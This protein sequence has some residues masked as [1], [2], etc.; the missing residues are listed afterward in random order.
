MSFRIAR[1][2]FMSVAL[3]A[4]ATVVAAPAALPATAEPDTMTAHHESTFRTVAAPVTKIHDVQGTTNT[5]PRAGQTVTVEGVVTSLFTTAD[6]LSGFFLQEEDADADTSSSTSEGVFVTCGTSCTTPV[7]VGQVARV[8]GEVSEAFNR[9]RISTN[10]A[11]G[12]VAVQSDL[13]PLP[14]PAT[15]TLPAA[16]STRAVDTFEALEGM[17]ITIATEMRVTEFFEEARFGHIVLTSGARPYT[18]THVDPTPTPEEHQ[19]FVADLNTRR[20]YLDDDN[21]D[22]NDA[23][24]GPISNEAYP[25]PTSSYTSNPTT[26]G[27]SITNRMRA[28]DT[29]SSLTGVMDWDFAGSASGSVNAW[30]IRP[31]Q[32]APYTFASTNPAPAAPEP[33]G[34]RLR[35]SAFNVL[36]YFT[37]ID[38]TASNST[39][40]CGPTGTADCRGADSEAELDR[41]RDK[42]IA[43]M[44]AMDADVAGLMEIQNDTG[45][46]TED[47]VT[48]LDA[49]TAPGTYE[50]IDT[51]SIGG[52]AIKVAIIYQPAMVTPVGAFR[53]LTSE[54]DPDFDDSRSRPALI[55]T[56]REVSTGATFTV[57]VNHLK[58]KGSACGADDPDTGDG[59][60]NCNLTR[61]KA[62]QALARYLATDPT[63]SGDPDVLILGDLNAYRYED[64]ITALKAAGYTDLIQQFLG[65]DA[66]SYLFDGQVG[67]LDHALATSS[68]TSQVTGVAEWHVNADEPPLFDYNDTVDDE[69]EASFERESDALPLDAPD[70]RRSSDHDPVVVGLSLIVEPAAPT[71][72][73]ATAGNG[74]ATVSWT[75]PAADGGSTITGYTVTSAPGGLTCTTATTSCTVTGL[76]N[77]TTYTFTVT[78]TNAA[79]TGPSSEPS[80]PVTP[81]A[82]PLPTLS[83]D[84]RTV[85]EGNRG[86]RS[87]TFTVTLSEASA[88]PVTVEYTTV[89][90][91]ATAP[92]D[93]TATAGTLT[94]APGEVATTIVV[95]ITGDALVESDE[96]FTVALSNPTSATIADDTGVGTITDTDVPVMRINDRNTTEGNSG[97]K[98][99][100]F[101]VR[102]GQASTRTVTVRYGTGDGSAVAG[103]DYVARSGTLTFSP[104]ERSKTITVQVRGDR[105][106]EPSEGFFVFLSGATNAR[107]VD[108][109][110]SGGILNDD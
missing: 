14:T 85:A 31:T 73:T 61:T 108:P 21:N 52:D 50:H 70:P 12:A 37:T 76:A 26:D 104:G 69:G 110:A 63:G 32:G 98:G 41:Q 81:V 100:V 49:A 99:L 101:T 55:Q 78:A 1:R 60:G 43:S 11:G 62:A 95:T 57:A 6:V 33:V 15:V 27:L 48:A 44:L 22:Q 79:G 65:D 80:D 4:G 23:I 18:Y 17:R 29:T 83:I 102:L 25:Y 3:A 71:A 16:G 84:D 72:V 35:A 89:D 28:G 87:M 107:L 106:R 58:S 86:T 67:Y 45:A 2:V 39:G 30:R 40:A 66:Y 77:G 75:P 10:V 91:S 34:G 13:S 53:V 42:M 97:L 5:S 109:N 96:T 20:I 54:I 88:E 8:T 64:P 51:G 103:S 46:S 105:V 59:A 90:G 7:S 36:N 82:P 68:L 9:T 38:T 94:F 74:Q 56:F 92:A 24:S 47:I 93:Y 19:A